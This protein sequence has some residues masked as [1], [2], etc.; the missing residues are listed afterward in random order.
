M[1][2]FF[3]K[4]Y[5]L[6]LFSLSITTLSAAASEPI[7]LHIIDDILDASRTSKITMRQCSF[8]FK[9]GASG[10]IPPLTAYLLSESGII[11]GNSDKTLYLRDL[12]Y[13]TFEL[14]AALVRLKPE[15]FKTT[16]E[17][18]TIFNNK[19]AVYNAFGIIS[20]TINTAERELSALADPKNCETFVKETLDKDLPSLLGEIFKALPASVGDLAKGHESEVLS[21][22]K[23]FTPQIAQLVNISYL[24]ISKAAQLAETAMSNF[25][26]A[27]EDGGCCGC[28]PSLSKSKK[29]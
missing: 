21:V 26:Q 28:F 1:K 20:N 17:I 5:T 23:K 6:I 2:N 16:P 13:L 7:E 10:V 19:D 9:D 11:S 25:V 14:F 22:A 12:S 29:K 8:D 27:I 15:E 4:I 18:V 24:G 3:I